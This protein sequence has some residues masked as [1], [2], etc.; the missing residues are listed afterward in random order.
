MLKGKR[1]RIVME[2]I[3]ICAHYFVLTVYFLS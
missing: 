3:Y 1:K 2:N